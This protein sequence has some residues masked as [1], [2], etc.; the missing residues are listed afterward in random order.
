MT[1][2]FGKLVALFILICVGAGAYEMYLRSPS[3]GAPEKTVSIANG[4]TL[5]E[6]AVQ[7]KAAGVI[8]S[9]TLFAVAAELYGEAKKIHPG[10]FVFKKGMSISDI[11]ATLS[12]VGK[13]EVS[14]TIPEGYNLTEIAERLVSLKVIKNVDDF[15]AVAGKPGEKI[16]LATDLLKNYPFLTSAPNLEGFL[17]P[18]TYRFYENSPALDVIIKMLDEFKVKTTALSPKFD[19]LILASIVEKEVPTADDRAL[20]ADLF[21]RRLK[22]GMPLQADSTV[23]YALHKSEL[24]LNANDLAVASAYN[25]YKNASLPPGPIANPGLSA[26]NAVLKPKTNSFWY[27]LTTKDGVVIYSRTLDE[28]NEMKAKYL[29]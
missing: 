12:Y 23:N 27:F 17:F 29:K 16:S 20:I 26:I 14:V 7:L 22:S 24:K 13:K 6:I 4:E 1:K 8:S 10:S 3:V 28:H 25:T 19:A 2:L 9:K 18:D 15:Y 11:L 5:D 21:L